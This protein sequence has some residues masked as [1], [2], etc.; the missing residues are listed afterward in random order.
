MPAE[1]L[2]QDLGAPNRNG[3]AYQ[4][5]AIQRA[6]FP[7]PLASVYMGVDVSRVWP[8]RARHRCAGV[9]RVPNVPQEAL[10]APSSRTSCFGSALVISSRRDFAPIS[11]RALSGC[12]Q[13][14]AQ[15][16]A[17]AHVVPT[18]TP[19]PPRSAW[20]DAQAHRSDMRSWLVLPVVGAAKPC[21]SPDQVGLML[22]TNLF[23]P[24]LA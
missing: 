8:S 5:F 1:T 19:N 16:R 3:N 20:M 11:L 23:S 12:H 24:P 7:Q 6:S 18:A 17:V 21:V 10:A 4:A 2:A 9:R 15:P 13:G 14:L 22:R